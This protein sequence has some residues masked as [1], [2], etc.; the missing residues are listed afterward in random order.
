MD[1]SERENRGDRRAF[2]APDEEIDVAATLDEALR[3]EMEDLRGKVDYLTMELMEVNENYYPTPFEGIKQIN[4][5]KAEIQKKKN[6][7]LERTTRAATKIQAYVRAW[8]ARKEVHD[9]KKLPRIRDFMIAGWGYLGDPLVAT[10]DYKGLC[11]FQWY[12]SSKDG[13]RFIP[14]PG[15]QSHT[16]IPTGDDVGHRFRAKC[17]PIWEDPHNPGKKSRGIPSI[18]E[19]TELEIDPDMANAIKRFVHTKKQA[20]FTV[21]PDDQ[22]GAT[23]MID[24]NKE[25]VKVL[26]VGKGGNKVKKYKAIFNNNMR[27]LLDPMNLHKFLLRMDGKVWYTFKVDTP[28][29]RNLLALTVRQ[30]RD[31]YLDKKPVENTGDDTTYEGP[32]TPSK[33]PS[34]RGVGVDN[35]M[36]VR[37]DQPISPQQTKKRTT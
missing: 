7:D 25:R 10:G 9:R 16:Y 1:V 21:Y 23:W 18:A 5:R 19:T 14:I 2:V 4:E 20:Q 22:P 11:Y 34:L 17:L 12:K 8:K 32:P 6:W 33:M 31:G 13:K 26:E 29:E 36:S 27:I 30:F 37:I 35:R 28:R 15:A 3:V 24:V